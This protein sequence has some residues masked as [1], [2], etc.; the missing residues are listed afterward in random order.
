NAAVAK[1]APPTANSLAVLTT[2]ASEL[3]P[4]DQAWAWA[5]AQVLG[6]Q[7]G[8]P[9]LAHRLSPATPTA[10]LSRII[11]PRQLPAYQDWI[12]CLVPT[13]KAGVGAG[14]GGTVST[15]NLAFSW[16][17]TVGQVTLPVYHYWTFSTGPNGDFE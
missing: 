15:N 3:P 2:P 7:T 17:G 1:V 5:H 8:A 6:R 16:S 11:A 13:F 9:S 4:A 14:R 10:N 12:A